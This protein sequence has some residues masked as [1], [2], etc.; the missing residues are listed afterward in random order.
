MSVNSFRKALESMQVEMIELTDFNRSI[1]NRLLSLSRIISASSRFFA[2][3]SLSILSILS[4]ASCA[5]FARSCIA[6][7]LLSRSRCSVRSWE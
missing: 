6:L 2:L 3:T 5:E 4:T 7:L 1:S